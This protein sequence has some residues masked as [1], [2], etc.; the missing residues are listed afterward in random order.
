[1]NDMAVLLSSPSPLATV[2]AEASAAID[3]ELNDG[4][5]LVALVMT[6]SLLSSIFIRR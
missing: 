3:E 1:M 5:V 6:S 2:T 4:F